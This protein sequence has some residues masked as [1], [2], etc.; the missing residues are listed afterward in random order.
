MGAT[1]DTAATEPVEPGSTEKEIT[2]EKV[3]QIVAGIAVIGE[4]QSALQKAG[5]RATIAGNRITA[6]D[7]IFAQFIAPS[8][9]PSAA[10]DARWVIYSI[11]GNPPVWIVGAEAQP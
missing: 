2:T 8:A 1:F 9:G 10:R 7:E 5:W 3:A 11:T 6:N 4:A